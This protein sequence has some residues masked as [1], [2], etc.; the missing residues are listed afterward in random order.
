[1]DRNKPKQ[2]KRKKERNDMRD[3]NFELKQ[4][5]RRN[6]DGSYTTHSDRE[7]ILW[8]IANLLYTLDFK[9]MTVQSLKSKHVEALIKHWKEEGLSPGT[10]KNRVAELRWWA[11]KI[12]KQNVVARGN[13]FYG[14][15]RRV[16]V[17][18]ISKARTLVAV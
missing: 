15:E 6:R 9:N 5:C 1:M 10:I 18:N 7:R 11:E 12:G 3:L 14:I 17:T 13:D 4:L 16:H 2:R 8:L